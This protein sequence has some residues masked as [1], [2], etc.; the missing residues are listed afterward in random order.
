[1]LSSTHSNLIANG[2]ANGRS[3]V[4]ASPAHWQPRQHERRCSGA[5]A[6]AAFAAAPRHSTS[7]TTSSCRNPLVAAA[8][9]PAGKGFGKPTSK[10]GGSK[11]PSKCPCGSGKM[12]ESCCFRY[13]A[14]AESAPTPEA[15]L[16][17]RFTAY[18][19]QVCFVRLLVASDRMVAACG[20]A[21]RGE[22]C[23]LACSVG[24]CSLIS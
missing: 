10:A 20:A 8:A 23:V 18:R 6:A 12:Y 17:A 19:M 13:H 11:A 24:P 14:G 1:M 16:R 7:T 21:T 9:A 3:F 4:A 22:G 15:L 2:K 5:P